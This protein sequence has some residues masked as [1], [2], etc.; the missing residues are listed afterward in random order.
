MLN[1]HPLGTPLLPSGPSSVEYDTRDEGLPSCSL[2][3]SVP[4]ELPSP[5]SPQ[6]RPGLV[7]KFFTTQSLRPNISTQPLSTIIPPSPIPPEI[8]RGPQVVTPAPGPAQ[9]ARSH[10]PPAH[11]VPIPVPKRPTRKPSMLGRLHAILMKPASFRRVLAGLSWEDVCSLHDTCSKLRRMLEHLS[12]PVFHVLL[13]RF[14]S[15]YRYDK[16]GHSTTATRLQI[17]FR[18]I[19][20]LGNSAK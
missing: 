8:R 16:Q 5:R 2:P 6:K 14:V 9:A 19:E 10:E 1:A 17:R 3:S 4:M 12:P 15:G 7:E 13:E 11:I 18:D 20:S